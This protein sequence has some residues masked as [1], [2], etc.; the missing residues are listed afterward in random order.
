MTFSYTAVASLPNVRERL[1]LEDSVN[2][3]AK[4]SQ[5]IYRWKNWIAATP[6]KPGVWRRKEG[7]YLVRARAKD[8]R[9]GKL[10]EVK[11]V[12][13]DLD[14]PG[15]YARLQ[16]ELRK[17]R[18]G[19]QASARCKPRFCDYAV[20]LVERKV[21]T[22]EIKSAASREQWAN[23]LRVHL[24][25]AFGLLY[26]DQIRRTDLEDW[27][28]KVAG[29]IESGK[30]SPA[31]ANGWLDKLRVVIN[32]A[33]IELELGRNPIAGFKPF[34]TSTR[35]TYTEEQPNSLTAPELSGFLRAV[36]E[37][38]PQHF[39]MVALGFATG[40]RPS[41]L[42][43]LR[44]KGPECDVI[45]EEGAIL[46]RRSHTLKQEVMNT[47]KT[48]LRQKIALPAEMMDILR[49]HVE[50][51]PE[52]PMRKSDL[53]FPGKD[54]GF[55]GCA[56][57]ASVYRRFT[58]K[59]GMKKR[60]TPRAMRRTFQDLARAAEVRDVVTRA[61]S[62]HATASMQQHYSTVSAD[63]MRQNLAKVVSLAGFREALGQTSGGAIGGTPS[64][65]QPS[66]ENAPVNQTPSEK[67]TKARTR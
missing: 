36:R 19:T 53:L 44:R 15:A 43:P 13:R 4:N 37:H 21:K 25:P 17:I 55:A 7:G 45:W 16:E 51:L 54:G 60:I 34:E 66:G 39:A 47:T 22:G 28:S 5:W 57:L 64:A 58:P 30:Y 65:M 32:S 62:G 42:R 29:L 48:G 41:S 61:V 67:G 18:E 27:R 33:Y 31:T 24:L 9:T 12:L 52:G 26:M 20:S 50:N 3:T 63:E 40:L 2:Q 38:H 1:R 46:V 59:L 14:G 10:K 56:S 49:W 8:S 11:L 35:P 23:D 6:S